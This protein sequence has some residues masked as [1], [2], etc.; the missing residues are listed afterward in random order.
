[1]SHKYYVVESKEMTVY[2]TEEE[3]KE[4]A[5]LGDGISELTIEDS[6]IDNE[7]ISL[8]NNHFFGAK[9]RVIVEKTI[10]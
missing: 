10:W 4:H 1:M 6:E 3:A 2:H 7:F 8:A 9:R 5:A